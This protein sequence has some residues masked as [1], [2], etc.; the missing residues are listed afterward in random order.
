M[1]FLT[2]VLSCKKNQHNF[3]REFKFNSYCS[4]ERGMSFIYKDMCFNCHYII[5]SVADK[6]CFLQLFLVVLI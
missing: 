2:I 4:E 3:F 5:V 6:I 1:L